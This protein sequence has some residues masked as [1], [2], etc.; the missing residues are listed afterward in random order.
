MLVA[1]NYLDPA[2]LLLGGAPAVQVRCVEAAAVVAAAAG[3]V[4]GPPHAQRRQRLPQ[5][6]RAGEELACRVD[7]G[8]EAGGPGEP[9]GGR[10]RQQ[11]AQH[12]LCHRHCLLLDSQQ[13]PRRF[14]TETSWGRGL[15]WF[16]S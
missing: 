1:V 2:P 16:G 9:A 7:E 3:S 12:C 8:A 13:Q 15:G 4:M 10:R 6:A 14:W 5:G 11:R